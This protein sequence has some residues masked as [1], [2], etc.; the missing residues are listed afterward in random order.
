MLLFFSL[1]SEGF[2]LP[3][4]G[5]LVLPAAGLLS[6]VCAGLMFWCGGQVSHSLAWGRVLLQ[7][8]WPPFGCGLLCSGSAH[9][10]SE[11]CLYLAGVEGANLAALSLLTAGLPLSVGL[12][13]TA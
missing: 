11:F 8:M 5:Y 9:F 2:Y 6:A 13:L 3:F 7:H 4:V 12:S 10:A 1:S